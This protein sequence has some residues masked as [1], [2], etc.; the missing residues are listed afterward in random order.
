M[1]HR[2]Q[3]QPSAAVKVRTLVPG[4]A[5]SHTQVGSNVSPGL[6]LFTFAS[7]SLP[8][9]QYSSIGYIN[10][11]CTGALIGPSTVLTAGG[12]LSPILHMWGRSMRTSF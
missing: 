12:S 3:Q 2:E 11:G 6:S 10:S 7:G 5:P 4:I 9:L 8:A 1:V